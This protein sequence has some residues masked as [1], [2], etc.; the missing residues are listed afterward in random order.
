MKVPKG[1]GLSSHRWV[2]MLYFSF[3]TGYFAQ[4][5]FLENDPGDAVK[6]KSSKIF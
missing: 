3:Q 2:K 1:G 5:S 6:A 4:I